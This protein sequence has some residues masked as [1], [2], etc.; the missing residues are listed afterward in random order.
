MRKYL[1]ASIFIIAGIFLSI[2]P[3]AASPAPTLREINA[4]IT[5]PPDTAAVFGNLELNHG[6]HSS[7][8]DCKPIGDDGITIVCGYRISQ[9]V[10]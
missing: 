4:E 8:V 2:D 7:K 6:H 3:S 9:D 10:G 1:F 5:P